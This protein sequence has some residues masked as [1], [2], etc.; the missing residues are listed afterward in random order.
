MS[1]PPYARHRLALF[2]TCL[3][4]CGDTRASPADAGAR[5]DGSSPSTAAPDA[6]DTASDH[7]ASP[8][9]GEEDAGG[10]L[11]DASPGTSCGLAETVRFS[12]AGGFRGTRDLYTLA[13]PSALVITRISAQGPN[14]DEA[15]EVLCTV[16]L[17]CDGKGADASGLIAA[18]ASAE[19]SSAFQ[20]TPALFGTDPRFYDGAVL[21]VSRMDGRMIELGDD[22]PDP[23]AGCSPI[24]PALRELADQL[25]AFMESVRP[26][27]AGQCATGP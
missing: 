3:T 12:W 23:A 6:S 1:S 22:C 27:D 17:A 9:S 7:D 15:G 20:P 19:V 2:A 10:A 26:G 25:K 5:A 18:L 21:R 4:A 8:T 11:V 24:T 14:D 16:S 13:P